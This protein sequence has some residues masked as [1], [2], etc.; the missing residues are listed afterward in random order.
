MNN[1]DSDLNLKISMERYI[2][3]LRGINVSGQ[4]LIKM[5][6]LRKAFIEEGFPEGKTFI[7]SGNLFFN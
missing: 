6:A 7:Q 4:K 3:F 1:L 5:D 2:A